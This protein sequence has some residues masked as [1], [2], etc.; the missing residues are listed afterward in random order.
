MSPLCG[1]M[2][3]NFGQGEVTGLLRDLGLTNANVNKLD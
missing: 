1:P 2:T 3:A